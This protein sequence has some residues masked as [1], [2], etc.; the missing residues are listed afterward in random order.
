MCQVLE[1]SRS[2]Y[3][4]WRRRP[5]SAREMANRRLYKKI[6]A[7]YNRSH[8][9]YGSPRI[10]W[11]LKRQGV[12]CSENR[13]ARLMRCHA[14]K[15]QQARRYSTTTKRTK[16]VRAAP[17]LLQRDFSAERPNEKWV[18]DITYIRTDEG[19]LY[20]AVVLD[21]FSRRVVGWAMAARMTRE[22]TI[23][24]LKMAVRQRQVG[25]DL[26]HH[27]DQGGQYT[28]AE[29]LQLLEDWGIQV[30]MNGAGTWYDNAAMESFFG[31]L[32]SEWVYRQKYH[33]RTQARTDIFYYIEAFYNRHR[34][35]SASDYF[36]P[37][38]YERRYHQGITFA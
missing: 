4:A 20:L 9:T 29:Y 14:L 32:K 16:G 23:A 2:G 34:L 36:S 27:S 37:E 28:A 25:P 8:K 26:L 21:L 7:V 5:P 10:Y 33:T 22:L 18:A 31:T 30:S 35:H 1:V 6:E 19:W 13:V 38:A 24:A 17:N 3:Y 11:A 15:A 12:A